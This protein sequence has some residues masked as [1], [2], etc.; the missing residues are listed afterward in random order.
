V[1]ST[2]TISLQETTDP[3]GLAAAQQASFRSNFAAVLVKGRHNYLSLRRLKLA[4]GRATSLFPSRRGIRGITGPGGLVRA[5]RMTD[6]WADL[7]HRPLGNVWDEG[8]KRHRQL[9]GAAMSNV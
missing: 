5:R 6:L 7:E 2:H 9:P 3:K 1:I 8:R 4:S